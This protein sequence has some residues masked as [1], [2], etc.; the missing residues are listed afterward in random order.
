MCAFFCKYAIF[1]IL[2]FPALCSAKTPDA[3]D[4][5]PE[6]PVT[7]NSTPQAF[8]VQKFDLNSEDE[9]KALLDLNN[10][11]KPQVKSQA[12]LGIHG[13]YSVRT[14]EDVANITTVYERMGRWI[15]VFEIHFVNDVNV[16][17]FV[18]ISAKKRNIDIVVSGAPDKEID[19]TGVSFVLTAKSVRIDHLK[20]GD[21]GF[22]PT[23][24]ADVKDSLEIDHVTLSDSQYDDYFAQIAEP[25]V[26][27][28]SYAED[29]Q[30]AT[31]TFRH[32]TF[33]NNKAASLLAIEDEYIDKFGTMT[34]DHLTVTDN[35]TSRMGIDVSAAQKTVIANAVISGHTG[36]PAL[37]QR[38]PLGQV[39][40]R[41]SKMPDDAY[42]YVPLPRYKGQT[43]KPVKK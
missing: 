23:L 37:V 24:T 14:P 17:K 34:F 10:A 32:L 2:F 3:P 16:T 29:G 28:R 40:I 9:I 25:R 20:W 39:E 6:G 33:K 30:Y 8:P 41:D 19:I 11:R 38:T 43:A 4:P 42:Q 15:S 36:S 31:A 35:K 26:Q 22:K 21:M 18:P 5:V 27:I 1:L 13:I 7:M 12:D